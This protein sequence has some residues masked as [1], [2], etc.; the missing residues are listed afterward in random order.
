MDGERVEFDPNMSRHDATQ[1]LAQGVGLFPGVD[2]D[3]GTPPE[4]PCVECGA[5]VNMA[6]PITFVV[7]NADGFVEH[8][9]LS[10]GDARTLL[11]QGGLIPPVVMCLEHAE[12]A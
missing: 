4:L 1:Y 9:V 12:L 3:F 10:E 5:M 11:V 2:T 7:E 8:K 6:S